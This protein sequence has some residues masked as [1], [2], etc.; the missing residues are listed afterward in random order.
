MLNV[1][2]EVVLEARRRVEDTIESQ[3][4]IATSLGI[5]PSTLSMW[6]TRGGWERPQ[7]AP[8]PPALGGASQGR[9]AGQ[10]I[11]KVTAKRQRMIA[12]LYRAFERQVA[13]MES[14]LAR[15]GSTLEEK[16]ARTLGTLARTLGTL[17][18]LEKD[19]SAKAKDTERSDNQDLRAELARRI[20]RWAEGR[21]ESGSVPGG[22]DG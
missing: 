18:A 9:T 22:A 19:D 12:R 17:M 10:I 5:P 7:G 14:R 8:L 16:D 1:S 15:A 2:P 20:R 11:D 3:T 6:K 21:A 13:E 4:A